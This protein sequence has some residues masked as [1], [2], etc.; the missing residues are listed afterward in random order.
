MNVIAG[1]LVMM[2]LV[3][4]GLSIEKAADTIATQQC[5]AKLK[6]LNHD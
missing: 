3:L 5:Q 2:G 4:L 1:W 6:E